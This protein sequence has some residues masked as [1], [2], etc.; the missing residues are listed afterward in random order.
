MD[1]LDRYEDEWNRSLTDF[2][3][4]RLRSADRKQ[5][6]QLLRDIAE[7]QSLHHIT[8]RQARELLEM[9]EKLIQPIQPIQPAAEVAATTSANRDTNRTYKQLL[10]F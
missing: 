9:A 3:K 6:E 10:L 2:L 4:E 5:R 7:M 1:L 8:K